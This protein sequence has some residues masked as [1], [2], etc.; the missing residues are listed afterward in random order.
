M[1]CDNIITLA[2]HAVLLALASLITPIHA[3]LVACVTA[4]Y[5]PNRID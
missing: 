1:S 4:F 5:M 2:V 3:R